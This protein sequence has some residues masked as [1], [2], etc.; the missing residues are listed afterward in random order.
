ML[1][2]MRQYTTRDGKPVEIVKTNCPGVFPILVWCEDKM[3]SYRVTEDGHCF[4]N[5]INVTNDLIPVKMKYTLQKFV[6]VYRTSTGKPEL[7]V[8]I[9]NEQKFAEDAGKCSRGKYIGTFPFSVDV[10]M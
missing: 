9:Y 7:G 4:D 10:E 8:S 5:Q 3:V 1:D 6:N 2:L